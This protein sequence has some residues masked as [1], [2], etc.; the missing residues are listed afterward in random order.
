STRTSVAVLPFKSHN[1]TGGD[2]LGVEIADALTTKLSESTH[3]VVSPTSTVLQHSDLLPH[4]AAAGKALNVDYVLSREVDRSRH[5][6]TVQ[7][8]R[9]RDGAPLLVTTMNQKFKNI[10]DLEDSLGPRILHDLMV[11]LGHEEVQRTRKRDTE[12]PAAYRAFLEGHYFMNK[13]EKADKLRSIKYFQK[14]VGL[15]PKYAMAYA[16]LSDC[17]MR[18]AAYG[19]APAEFVPKSR[20]AVMQALQLDDTVAYAHS[21]L[22]RIAFL[23]DWDFNRAGFE[24]RR[25]RELQPG[26]VH[27]WYASYLLILNKPVEAEEENRKFSEVLPFAPGL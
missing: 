18:L 14:A 16:G 1:D 8:G 5:D 4:A 24:Y 10:F 11:T 23:Y 9:I 27:Q 13:P 20:A 7:L 26:L 21:M 12:N 15:D 25:A 6:V 17:Y 19:V 3:L 22:G 2:D